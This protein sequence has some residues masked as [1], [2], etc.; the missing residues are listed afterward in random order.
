MKP[1]VGCLQRGLHRHHLAGFQRNVGVVGRIRHR[2]AVGEPRRFVAD[3]A[4][5]VR[6]EF[7]VVVV[8]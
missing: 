3:Q 8:L 7:D 5:A 2:P 4:H 6:E 1:R